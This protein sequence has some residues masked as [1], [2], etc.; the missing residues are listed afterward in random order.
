MKGGRLVYS[1]TVRITNKTGLHARP[2]SEFTKKASS[3]SADITITFK[4]RKIN[5]KS[6]VGLLSAGITCGSDILISAQGEDE[7]LAVE[8]MVALIQTNFGE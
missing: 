7:Q 1:K 8:S 3:F 2:A 5:G 6:I 4:E